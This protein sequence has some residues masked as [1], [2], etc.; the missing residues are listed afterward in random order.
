MDK[1]ILAYAFLIP[2]ILVFVALIADINLTNEYGFYTAMPSF[3]IALVLAFN[4]G[5]KGE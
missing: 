4:V 2:F 3:G 5:M 1:K